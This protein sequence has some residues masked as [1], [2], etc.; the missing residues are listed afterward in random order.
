MKKSW[1]ILKKD[2]PTMG[3]G[4]KICW[5][6][7]F[8]VLFPLLLVAVKYGSGLQQ[9]VKERQRKLDARRKAKR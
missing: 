9:N 2:W 7:F 4:Q 6:L 1:G 3:I 5:V 8:W